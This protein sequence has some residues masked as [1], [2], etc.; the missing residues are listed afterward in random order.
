M[1]ARSEICEAVLAG[2]SPSDLDTVKH[3][4]GGLP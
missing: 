1:A 4:L 3:T 2:I